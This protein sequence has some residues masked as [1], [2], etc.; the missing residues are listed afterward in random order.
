MATVSARP[1][2]VDQAAAKVVRNDAGYWGGQL[3]HIGVALVVISLATTNGLAT[4]TTVTIPQ[5][6]TAA[7]GGYCLSYVEPFARSEP[8]REVTGIRV[9]VLDG[10]CDEVLAV[11]EPR[12]NT[13][14][15]T[16]QPI[17]TPDVWTGLVDDVYVGIAG[18][19]T[20]SVDLNVFVFPFQWMLWIG[21]LVIVAGGA[22]ALVRKPLERSASSD[23]VRSEPETSEVR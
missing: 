10:G 13:Y 17:G 14:A 9:A 3:A 23:V 18:G 4:R 15:G 21:G 8:N 16:S 19:T 7:V 11:L 12:L 2:R 20:E 22:L 1:E 6:E 5:G